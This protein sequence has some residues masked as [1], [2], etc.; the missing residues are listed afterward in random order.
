MKPG[1]DN[2]R[3]REW[4]SRGFSLVE[5]LGVIILIGVISLGAYIY[6]GNA[7]QQA[8]AN[9]KIRNAQMLNQL[10]SISAATGATIATGATNNIDTTSKLTAIASL[11]NGFTVN[12]IP[13]KMSPPILTPASYTMS[14]TP[15]NILFASDGNNADPP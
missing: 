13:F 12:S 9:T 10:V 15:P 7:N 8:I 4:S 5:L 2:S 6:V 14:G 3:R 1:I 11:N